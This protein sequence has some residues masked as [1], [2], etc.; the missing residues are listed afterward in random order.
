MSIESE[1]MEIIARV[2]VHMVK[3]K[4]L[5]KMTA[6]MLRVSR[7]GTSQMLSHKKFR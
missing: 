4:V 7:L 5:G 2:G 1:I 3:V 6:G